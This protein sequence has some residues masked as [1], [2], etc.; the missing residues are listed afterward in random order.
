VRS[1]VK[2]SEVLRT[3]GLGLV[4]HQWKSQA[5]VQNQNE[6]ALLLLKAFLIIDCISESGNAIASVRP[7]GYLLR[8]LTAEIHK[9][10]F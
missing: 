7:S 10:F 4:Y 8:I 2:A 1:G 5:R 6:T 9:L 3:R